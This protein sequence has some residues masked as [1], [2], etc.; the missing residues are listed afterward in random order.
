[1]GYFKLKCSQCG[2][3]DIDFGLNSNIIVCNSCGKGDENVDVALIDTSWT[4]W[5]EED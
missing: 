3:T 2:S 1:M 4:E 5:I